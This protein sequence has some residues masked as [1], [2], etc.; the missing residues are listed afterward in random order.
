MFGEL[1]FLDSVEAFLRQ[2]LFQLFKE[3]SVAI[4][5]SLL[6]LVAGAGFVIWLVAFKWFPFSRKIRLLESATRKSDD[7][8]G[9]AENFADVDEAAVKD[10]PV[11]Y[12]DLTFVETEA[13]NLRAISN[14]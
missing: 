13:I 1:G 8:L 2:Y 4:G 14:E 11:C 7:E 3:P 5:L 6:L 12:A 10:A 9:F